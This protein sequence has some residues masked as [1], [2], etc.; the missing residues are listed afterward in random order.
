[1]ASQVREPDDCTELAAAIELQR[2]QLFKASAVVDMCR[3]ACA[4]QFEGFDIEQ[5]ALAL[6]VAD[7]LVNGAASELHCL[8]ATS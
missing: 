2:Q 5:L 7:E 6:Q 3:H 8:C 4:S 1:M